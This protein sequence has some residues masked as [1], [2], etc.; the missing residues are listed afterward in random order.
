MKTKILG[1]RAFMHE[2]EGK[3]TQGKEDYK[4][5]KCMSLRMNS[6]QDIPTIQPISCST[7]FFHDQEGGV[8]CF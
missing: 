8:S 1:L 2:V 3:A 4:E 5:K 7:N 6:Y